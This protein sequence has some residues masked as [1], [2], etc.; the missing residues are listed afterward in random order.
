MQA[1]KL[2][3]GELSQTLVGLEH[4][5]TLLRTCIAKHKLQGD[6]SLVVYYERQRDECKS[7]MTYFLSLPKG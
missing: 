2:T 3:A 7:A 6:T 5:D 1:R 4:R